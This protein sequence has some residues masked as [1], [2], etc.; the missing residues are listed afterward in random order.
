MNEKKK[1]YINGQYAGFTTDEN[2]ELRFICRHE[3]NGK[4]CNMQL[5]VIGAGKHSCG[6]NHTNKVEMK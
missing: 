4:K 6:D 3:E 1:I 5:T 2:S